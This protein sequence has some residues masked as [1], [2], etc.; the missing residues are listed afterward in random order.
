MLFILYFN[1]LY[2]ESLHIKQSET[3]S[4]NSKSEG[5]YEILEFTM[6]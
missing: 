2:S 3:K 1:F 6:L 5:K 4:E